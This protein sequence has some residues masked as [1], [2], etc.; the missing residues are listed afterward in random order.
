MQRKTMT[1]QFFDDGLDQLS[2]IEAFG[3]LAVPH[4]FAEYRN[5]FGIGIGIEVVAS[6][7]QDGFQ[8]LV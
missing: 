3:G 4:V 8:L 5:S 2:E 6:F 1:H 7:G